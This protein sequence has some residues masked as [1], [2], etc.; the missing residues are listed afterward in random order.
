MFLDFY[1]KTFSNIWEN[2][3]NSTIVNILSHMHSLA[4]G[5]YLS[6]HTH[7]TII[8]AVS[9]ILEQVLSLSLSLMPLKLLKSTDPLSKISLNLDL[10]AI[11][12]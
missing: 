10:S 1:F 2:Y 4:L 6:T 9:F 8:S 11:S 5:I 3:K 7:I 12:L